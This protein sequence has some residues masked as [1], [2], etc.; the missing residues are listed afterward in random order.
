MLQSYKRWL[1]NNALKYGSVE[2]LST[3]KFHPFS[4]LA[5]YPIAVSN[6]QKISS[7]GHLKALKS[8]KGQVEGS[9]SD[10]LKGHAHNCGCHTNLSRICPGDNLQHCYLLRLVVLVCQASEVWHK[11]L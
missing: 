6:E 3:K 11:K 8:L 9:E 4:S 2:N 7:I 10:T 5:S 1:D